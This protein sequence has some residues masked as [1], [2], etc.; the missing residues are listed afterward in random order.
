MNREATFK[1]DYKARSFQ[2]Q[3]ALGKLRDQFK[4]NLETEV[5]NEADALKLFEELSKTKGEQLSSAEEAFSLMEKENG[6][7]GMAKEDAQLESDNLASQI[8]SDSA[9]SDQVQEDLNTKQ[10]EWDDRSKIR[11]DEMA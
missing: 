7:R 10:T 4:T 8:Q 3:D 11:G 6:A 2:I 5:N 1:K 9:Y